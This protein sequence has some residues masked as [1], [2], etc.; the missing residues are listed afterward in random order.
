MSE[1]PNCCGGPMDPTMGGGWACPQCGYVVPPW[2]TQQDVPDPYA[3]PD[4]VVPEIETDLSLELDEARARIEE[5]EAE[6][7]DFAHAAA[8]ELRLQNELWQCIR[9]LEAMHGE[10]MRVAQR[11][12][13]VMAGEVPR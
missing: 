5:L 7:G 12:R 4:I 1:A 8:R 6:R 13:E 3:V 11:A 9:V 2:T 10:P